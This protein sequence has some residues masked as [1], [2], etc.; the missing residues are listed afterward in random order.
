MKKKP[1]KLYLE[2]KKAGV[3]ECMKGWYCKSCIKYYKL[4]KKNPYDDVIII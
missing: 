3:T 1:S 2:M 4:R